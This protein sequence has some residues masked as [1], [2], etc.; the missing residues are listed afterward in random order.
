MLGIYR[1]VFFVF[2]LILSCSTIAANA[3]LENSDAV[4]VKDDDNNIWFGKYISA[5]GDTIR[6]RLNPAGKNISYMGYKSFSSKIRRDKVF[7]C[8]TPDKKKHLCLHKKD[9][10]IYRVS[11]ICTN[12]EVLTTSGINYE[13]GSYALEVDRIDDIKKGSKIIFKNRKREVKYIFDDGYIHYS[14]RYK[15]DIYEGG[16]HKDEVRLIYK[17]P[18]FKDNAKIDRA[19]ES[20]MISLLDESKSKIQ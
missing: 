3:D 4:V 13:S 19:A 12:G 5:D 1:F 15:G 7:P 8:R 10:S 6:V 11:L 20:S 18:K 14:Y 2:N 16:A 9:R 17:R